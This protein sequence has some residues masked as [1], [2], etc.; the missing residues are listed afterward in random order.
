MLRRD[1]GDLQHPGRLN[2]LYLI[3]QRNHVCIQFH[4]GA[5]P[6]LQRRYRPGRIGLCH[7]QGA[8]ALDV[9]RR[10]RPRRVG[11]ADPAVYIQ[12]SDRPGALGPQRPGNQCLVLWRVVTAAS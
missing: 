1:R 11:R 7:F 5:R 12:R 6:D 9:G 3:S 8:L 4:L 2:Q 10:D